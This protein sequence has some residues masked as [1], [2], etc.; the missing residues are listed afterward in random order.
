MYTAWKDKIAERAEQLTDKMMNRRTQTLRRLTCTCLMTFFTKALSSVTGKLNFGPWVTN[1]LL[2][3]SNGW[4]WIVFPHI[5]MV[6]DFCWKKSSGFYI[7]GFSWSLEPGWCIL[8]VAIFLESSE[9]E[10]DSRWTQMASSLGRGGGSN[11]GE[12]PGGYRTWGFCNFSFN[13]GMGR[14]DDKTVGRHGHVLSPNRPYT[15]QTA[16]QS[17]SVSQ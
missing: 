9:S 15:S 3:H 4:L 7:S 8:E 13:W 2:L 1:G 16:W 6:H 12:D 10:H 17:F 14:L 11:F 5:G